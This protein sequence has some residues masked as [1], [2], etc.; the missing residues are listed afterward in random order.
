MTKEQY[1][2]ILGLFADK[3]KEQENTIN[4]Y[5]WQVERLEKELQEAEALYLSS[6][7]G[8]EANKETQAE[9]GQ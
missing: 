2:V 6:T 7:R 8:I 4:L 5:K 3:I 9:G 1:E